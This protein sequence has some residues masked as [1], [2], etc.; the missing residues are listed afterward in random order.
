MAARVGRGHLRRGVFDLSS[1]RSAGQIAPNPDA[2][3][4]IPPLSAVVSSYAG[5]LECVKSGKKLFEIGGI[6]YVD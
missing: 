4:P 5:A 2:S 3:A 6:A 1:D